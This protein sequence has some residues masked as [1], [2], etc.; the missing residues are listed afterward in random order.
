MSDLISRQD[1]KDAVDMA[2][3]NMDHVPQWVV[4]DL[5]NALD[6][7]PSAE[8]ETK[9]IAEIK[10]SKEDMQSAVDE[11]VEKIMAEMEVPEII[12]CKDCR[13]YEPCCGH[14]RHWERISTESILVCEN[15]FCSQA[16]RK[17]N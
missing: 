12:R 9:L 14:C 16:E 8:P 5:L 13:N 6:E 7:V 10:I 15:D 1:A 17:E 2:L 4:D 11:A 3:D